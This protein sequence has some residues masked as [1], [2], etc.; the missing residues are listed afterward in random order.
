MID[1]AKL[2]EAHEK[3]VEEGALAGQQ[4]EQGNQPS[5]SD[6]SQPKNRT[7]IAMPRVRTYEL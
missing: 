2:V 4:A 6:T 5:G 1:A 3:A 7:Y